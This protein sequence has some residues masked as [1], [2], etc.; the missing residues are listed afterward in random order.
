MT[1]PLAVKPP[2]TSRCPSVPRK[3]KSSSLFGWKAIDATS[4]MPAFSPNTRSPSTSTSGCTT[5]RRRRR[6]AGTGRR[7]S[8]GLLLHALDVRI[9]VHRVGCDRP[10]PCHLGVAAEQRD[11]ELVRVQRVVLGAERVDGD[12]AACVALVPTDL[13]WMSPSPYAQPR[14]DAFQE[15]ISSL[16]PKPVENHGDVQVPLVTPPAGSW[17]AWKLTLYGCAAFVGAAS[18]SASAS[19]ASVPRIT[20]STL[21]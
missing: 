11:A 20:G 1:S 15:A 3:R 14:V 17:K 18:N 8:L 9:R 19:A 4:G 6:T 2:M 10:E 21:T 16:K 12:V 5:P 13:C 7:G